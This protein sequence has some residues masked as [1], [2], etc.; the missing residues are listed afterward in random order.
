MLQFGANYADD[1]SYYGPQHH[2]SLM[3]TEPKQ[4]DLSEP[5]KGFSYCLSKATKMSDSSELDRT[6]VVLDYS[7]NGLPHV[8][9]YELY[10]MKL[11]GQKHFS[12]FT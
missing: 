1:W 12:S 9:E 7:R 2:I 6:S 10:Y 8:A 11:F 3:E 5:V 4:A